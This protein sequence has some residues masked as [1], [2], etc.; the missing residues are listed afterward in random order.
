MVPISRSSQAPF[1]G[2]ISTPASQA[3]A[4]LHQQIPQS[5]VV[6]DWLTTHN[7]QLVVR[8]TVHVGTTPL[9]SAMAMASTIEAAEDQ[10]KV[11]AIASALAPYLNQLSESY[12]ALAAIPRSHQT[13]PDET[14][15]DVTARDVTTDSNSSENPPVYPRTSP[16][17]IPTSMHPSNSAADQ[18]AGQMADQLSDQPSVS[19]I[20]SQRSA[21]DSVESP[22]P[23]EDDADNDWLHSMDTPDAPPPISSLDIEET[24]DPQE[25][26][27]ESDSSPD[28]PSPS[29]VQK[30]QKKQSRKKAT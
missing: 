15:Q 30:P 25:Q 27:V 12:Q 29:S 23:E 17:Q 22:P 3:I 26:V 21:Q 10:A 16:E 28:Q 7:D 1:D 20:H 18:M 8:A 11:R 6:T 4:L 24:L 5:A 14:A 9:A 19:T 2:V 13:A